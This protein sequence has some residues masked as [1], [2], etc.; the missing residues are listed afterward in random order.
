[1]VPVLASVEAILRAICPDLPMP[2]TTTRPVR[3]WI[4]STAS[5]N[6]PSRRSARAR[7]ASAS[8]EST[9]RASSRAALGAAL[10]AAFII[11]AEYSP[12]RKPRRKPAAR[13]LE[14]PAERVDVGAVLRVGGGVRGG[15]DRRV[16][17]GLQLPAHGARAD[18]AVVHLRVHGD[19]DLVRDVGR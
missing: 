17:R 5:R 8:M 19:G 16:G 11:A 2:L 7:T 6:R 3:R 18:E 1:G 13:R 10:R 4:S 15:V 14:R 12:G 9:L